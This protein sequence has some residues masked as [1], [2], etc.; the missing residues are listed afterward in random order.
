M[1]LIWYRRRLVRKSVVLVA[2]QH[3]LLRC[4]AVWGRRIR[5]RRKC[6]IRIRQSSASRPRVAHLGTRDRKMR[7]LGGT[8]SPLRS[9]HDGL[10]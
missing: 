8:T 6:V 7:H 5:E 10:Q 2:T 1:V 4:V 9:R 3:Q